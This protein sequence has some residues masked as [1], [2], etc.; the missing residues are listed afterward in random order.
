M[1]KHSRGAVTV[2]VTLLLIPAVLVSGTGVDISRIYAAR[3]TAR[4]ANQLAANALMTN[5]DALL[6]DLY[7]LYA[8][9]GDDDTLTGMVDLYVR[10][11]LFGEDVEE[12]QMGEFRLF[13]G[14]E[15][16]SAAASGSEPL[17]N[18]EILRRQIEEF[19][20]YRVPVAIISDIVDRLKDSGTSEMAA[21][22]EAAAKKL[23]VD[24]QFEDALK[25]YNDVIDKADQASVNYLADEEKTYKAVN[26]TVSQIRYQLN[27][28]LSIRVE[29]EAAFS[30][31]EP[32]YE[33]ENDI[34]DHYKAVSDNISTCA[35]GG[36]IGYNWI[37]AHVDDE[38]NDVPGAW[39][40]PHYKYY[41]GLQSTVNQGVEKLEGHSADLEELVQL[42]QEAD[43]AKGALVQKI[44]ELEAKL[45]DGTCSPELVENMRAE[46]GDAKKLLAY[47]FTE[48][49]TQMKVTANDYIV[50]TST[51]P[52]K[53]IDGYGTGGSG[54]HISFENLQDVTRLS[55]YEIDFKIHTALYQ[56]KTDRLKE[57][58]NALSTYVAPQRYPTFAS[59][60]DAHR[61]CYDLIKNG[62]FHVKSE[63]ELTD[64]E[65]EEKGKFT[66]AFKAMKDLWNG[67]TNYDPAPGAGSYPNG[68][69]NWA[70]PHRSAGMEMDFFLGDFNMDD[71]GESGIRGTLK[72]F[73][74]LITGKT[75]VVELFGN[76]LANASNRV[77]LVGYAT[78]M[79]SN[80]NLTNTEGDAPLSLTGQPIDAAHNYFYNSEWEYIINGNLDAGKNLGKATTTILVIRFLANYAS[81]YMIK[82]VNDEIRSTEE[83]VSAIPYAGGVLRFLVRPLYVLG[84]SVVDV[85][86]L[87]SGYQIPLLK[88]NSRKDTWN[89][90]LGGILSNAVDEAKSG[91]GDPEKTDL[92]Y[93]DYLIIFMLVSEPEILASRI[94]DLIALN[95]T[96]V[97]N[98][99]PQ[100]S[101]GGADARADAAGGAALLDLSK[102]NTTFEVKTDTRVRFMFLSMPFAQKGLNE[103]VPP[104]TFPVTVTDYRGY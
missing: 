90:S 9:I 34:Q 104:T 53:D 103:I 2:F 32:D 24:E 13:W 40:N 11:S 39:E 79:F 12:A 33:K 84:E 7:G 35:S 98:N 45:D 74:N 18:V 71:S 21:N 46:L 96:T 23:A 78:Q 44:N 52:L 100:K 14:H 38:G 55:G 22:T 47:N 81:S 86:L 87:R 59:I 69:G 25:K 58:Q 48:L 29:Y 19:S 17:S 97:K 30:S 61:E 92:F 95:V 31:G 77:L 64:R 56:G 80:W 8:V 43:A 91:A 67:L 65:K 42:C 37:P 16:V 54:G 66:D 102:A 57:I 49:G 6:Q 26:E 82:K 85:S 72:T 63:G 15:S 73:S 75:D 51:P 5:Y 10:A 93:T 76:V 20:K 99:L 60:S 4:D 41:D 3:S 36:W 83:L 101:K 62:E 94:G 88:T 89:F 50:S 27:D 1:R 70:F 68:E 28:M